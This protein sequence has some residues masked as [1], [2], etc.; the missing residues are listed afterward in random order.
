MI[1]HLLPLRA[2]TVRLRFLRRAEP[3]FFHQPLLRPFL[4]E[5][6]RDKQALDNQPGLWLEAINSGVTR[7]RRG[8]EYRFNLFCLPAAYP[9]FTRV[10][11]ALRRLPDSYPGRRPR[12]GA[13]AANLQYLGLLDY[14]TA[15]PVKRENELFL[16]DEQALQ[17]E[18][19][20][21][22]RQPELILR[23][24]AP[25]R[26]KRRARA[27]GV[28]YITNRGQLH[29][30]ELERRVCKALANLVPGPPAPCEPDQAS[31]PRVTDSLFW[32]DNADTLDNGRI[33]PFGG[34][35]GSVRLHSEGD[36]PHLPWLILGQYTGMG[37]RRGYG[38]GRYYL[39]TPQGE[40]TTPPPALATTR[41]SACARIGVFEQA[42]RN[43]ARK[44]PQVRR[45]ID[46]GLSPTPPELAELLDD[47]G[48]LDH[49]NLHHLARQL[50][51][52]S[53]RAPVL[54]GVILRRPGR[55][56]RPLA[57]PPL[58]DRIIQRAVVE[59]LGPAIER[60]AM[61]HSYG[62]RRGHSRMQ[63]RDRI[64]ALYRQGYRW[65]FEADITEFFDLVPHTEISNRLESFFPH[66]PLV[67]LIMDWVGAPVQFDGRIIQRHTGLPQ[68][69]PI[70]PMLA[71]LLLEDFDADLRAQNMELVRFA[72]DFVVLCKSRQQALAAAR[73]AERSLAELGLTFN[74]EKTG[75]GK[76][77][78]G[79]DF[80]GYS[81]V[82]DLAV[83]KHRPRHPPGK[84]RLDDIPA[85]SWLAQL[86]QREPQLLDELNQRLDR[87][88]TPP[89]LTS[90]VVPESTVPPADS[91]GATLFITPPAK[92]LH[93]RGGALEVREAQGKTLLIREAW[94]DLA[95]IVLI[96]R[97]NL[98]LPCQLAAMKNQVP[99]HYCNAAGRYLGVSCHHHP[100]TEGPELWLLQARH[101]AAD[102]PRRLPLCRA[103]VSA[104]IHNQMQ[105]LR[106]RRRH[107]DTADTA[108]A[109]LQTLLD[110]CN[111]ADEPQLLGYEGQA[112][113]LYLQ[114]IARWIPEEYGFRQ[115]N[116][117]P[118]R[119][120][121]NAMLSL[122]Y[123]VLYGQA[124]SVLQVAGLYPW[125]GFYHHRR[126]R[127]LALAS[128]LMEP[129]RHLVERT[130][131]TLLRSGQLKQD[132]FYIRSDNAC[133]LTR[134][135][136]RIFL[137]QLQQRILRPVLARDGDQKRNHLEH[138]LQTAWQ[139]IRHLRDPNQQVNFFRIK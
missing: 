136:R 67:P 10:L 86:L 89:L 6:I 96:G 107:D 58:A 104:R 124:A 132:D 90:R 92:R 88:R 76:M 127:H 25:A 62:Y 77:I 19:D 38:M 29:P 74:P 51:D 133:Y 5:L 14:F 64:Q 81:F 45:L 97:H 93:H 59:V 66:E 84:L 73:R 43:M 139:L 9:L 42:C 83:E 87:P 20:F 1:G 137:Q 110:N 39:H 35:M 116:R 57:I 125:Q 27:D 94:N 80:L 68:G 61:R 16:Y 126:D 37:E 46:H 55:H 18:V 4:K 75:V 120:P 105:V 65:F 32:T 28:S 13:F 128:D 72:D 129:H 70:S 17:R 111:Q 48:A 40:G 121:F 114:Q 12:D 56:P 135:G 117:R 112:T 98:T 2:V 119:D 8:D 50:A 122:G 36:A 78:D 91:L 99:I 131:L 53:Y 15:K 138:M 34:V 69:S 82:G 115:R 41:L 3:P 101:Y 30:G 44:H 23:F 102:S 79:F 21:W 7:F 31:Y 22:R 85:A 95:A 11:D 24:T 103:L 49:I 130:A 123:S 33:N 100:A 26:L 52:G 63:A 60:L 47:Q 54:Q 113:A 109:A 118:P 71:N 106:Q 134:D 108:M